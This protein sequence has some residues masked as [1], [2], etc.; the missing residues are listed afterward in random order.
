MCLVRSAA[1]SSLHREADHRKLL[2]F[3]TKAAT[4]PGHCIKDD[5]KSAHQILG[6]DTQN[7]KLP[8]SPNMYPALVGI[9]R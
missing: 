3:S 4:E 1:F 9:V 8:G 2:V 6:R 5:L 7:S